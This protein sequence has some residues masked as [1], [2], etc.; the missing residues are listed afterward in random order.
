MY[1][2]FKIEGSKDTFEFITD[3]VASYPE[4]GITILWKIFKDETSLRNKA[5]LALVAVVSKPDDSGAREFL[6]DHGW[7]QSDIDHFIESR[8]SHSSGFSGLYCLPTQNLN[9]SRATLREKSDEI[10]DL[11]S[12][13]SILRQ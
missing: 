3:I 12:S 6:I 11:Y 4:E 13:N 2:K 10:F 9:S 5:L 1:E 7:S 8:T